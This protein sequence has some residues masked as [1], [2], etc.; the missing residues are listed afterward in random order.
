MATR[1][2]AAKRHNVR[3]ESQPVSREPEAKGWLLAPSGLRGQN[4]S[5]RGSQYA[6]DAQFPHR[7]LA[8]AELASE[9][10]LPRGY[11]KPFSRNSP[12]V[13]IVVA[14]LIPPFRI[15]CSTSDIEKSRATSPCSSGS[16]AASLLRRP[17]ARKI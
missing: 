12:S 4:F 13:A 15:I 6:S 5:P 8:D 14:S 3:N 16:G 17:E 9:G 11:R 2:C 1:S 10:H 7:G